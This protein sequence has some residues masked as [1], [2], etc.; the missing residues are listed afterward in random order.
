MAEWLNAPVLKTGVGKP[1]KGSNPFPSAKIPKASI[2]GSG[3]FSWDFGDSLLS[4]AEE[5][6]SK[7][8]REAG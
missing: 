8:C 5:A 7:G 2:F 6:N 4:H 1:I 3:L